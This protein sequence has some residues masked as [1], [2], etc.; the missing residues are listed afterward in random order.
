MLAVCGGYQNL[1]TSVRT[2]DGLDLVGPGVFPVSTE[3]CDGARRLV[4][5]TVIAMILGLLMLGDRPPADSRRSRHAGGCKDPN[6]AGTRTL[7]GFENHRGRP[8]L[9]TGARAFATVELGTATTT[10][11]GPR[12]RACSLTRAAAGL[13]IGTYLHGPLLPRNPHLADLLIGCALGHGDP[14]ELDPIADR[15]EWRAHADACDSIRRTA[16]RER[17]IP[18]WGHRALDR[19][20]ALVRFSSALVH[21]PQ[22][23]DKT[24]P[25]AGRRDEAL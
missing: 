19:V 8:N 3:V 23:G 17:R 14:V 2:R 4:G 20:G 12:G 7:V 5:P 11:M 9:V 1:G 24:G 15:L 22:D 18:D 13:R 6:R 25:H 10:W 16:Q 21:T